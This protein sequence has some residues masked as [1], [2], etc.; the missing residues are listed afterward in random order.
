M[1]ASIAD[2]GLNLVEAER[3]IYT[4]CYCE[5]NIYKLCASKLRLGATEGSLHVVFIS[6]PEQKVYQIPL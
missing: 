4:P 6:N 3:H 5:E 1:L 2:G